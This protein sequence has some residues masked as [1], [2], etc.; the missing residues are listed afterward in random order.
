MRNDHL[1]E[2]RAKDRPPSSCWLKKGGPQPSAPRSY[3][4]HSLRTRP[5]NVVVPTKFFWM[6][7]PRFFYNAP[8]LGGGL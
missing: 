8:T 4:L 6:V 2:Q 5:E 7:F 1:C 3:V